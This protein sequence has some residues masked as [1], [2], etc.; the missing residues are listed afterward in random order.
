MSTYLTLKGLVELGVDAEI[1]MYQLQKGGLLRGDDVSIHFARRPF[2]KKFHYSRYLKR[3][4]ISLGDYDIYHAQG[5]WLYPT[6][7]IVD[8]ARQLGRPYLITPR[9]MLYPQDIAK[10]NK[11]IKKLFLKTRLLNDLNNATCVHA[12]CKDEMVYCRN[13]G[14]TSPIAVIPNPVEIKEYK[15]QEKDGVFRLGYLGRLSPR[16]NVE[17]L[18][19]AFSE[20][21]ND[22][23]E[24]ELI[25]IGGGD[26]K[27]EGFLREE[28]KKLGL[29]NVSFKGFLSGEEKERTLSSISVLAMPSEFENLGN[30]ILEGLVHR[31]PCIATCGSPWEEL[32]TRGCGW[33]VEYNQDAIS[34]AVKEAFMMSP[35]ILKQMGG[36]GRQLMIDKYSVDSVA[37]KMKSLYEWVIG[38]SSRPDF[39]Y[40]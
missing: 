17:S 16:K 38:N 31:I 20:L 28:A 22:A 6:Y 29:T 25:I 5:V 34:N 10:S 19:Y 9:G 12:T 36:N 30:V 23:K 18:I 3:E 27:Y 21:R 11:L 15:E 33:W 2:E 14:V 35:G 39:V 4:V 26:Q 8:V 7:C 13:L 40:V 1:I 37:L 24:A 32:N